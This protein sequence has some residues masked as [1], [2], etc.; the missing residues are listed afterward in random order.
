MFFRHSYDKLIYPLVLMVV[1]V[2][3]SF[4]PKYHLRGDMPPEFF[5]AAS[6]SSTA[7]KGALDQRIAWA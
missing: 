2:A 7:A 5:R 6:S 1:L 4:R 3:V